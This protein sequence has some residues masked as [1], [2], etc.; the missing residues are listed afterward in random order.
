MAVLGLAAPAG[1]DPLD[2]A[3]PPPPLTVAP[4]PGPAPGPAPEAAV[5][6]QAAGPDTAAM[7]PAGTPHLAS[8]DALP[9]GTTMDPNAVPADSPNVSYLKDLWQAVQSHEISGKEALIMGLAQRGMNTPIPAQAPGPNVP[10]TP[11]DPAPAPPPGPLPAPPAPPVSP[12]PP[13]P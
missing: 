4:A 10:I 3:P 2:P 7:P 1:A 11:G 5:T 12:L 6:V 13:T 9:P 8:P